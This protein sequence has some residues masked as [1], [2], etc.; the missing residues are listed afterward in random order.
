[1]R[2]QRL[3]SASTREPTTN[4]FR[5]AERHQVLQR[6]IGLAFGRPRGLV[7]KRRRSRR[8][9]SETPESASRRA[10]IVTRTK[11]A[12]FFMKNRKSP[13]TS[14]RYSLSAGRKIP[15][16]AAHTFHHLC[17]IVPIS[18]VFAPNLRLLP[19]ALFGSFATCVSGSPS[20][21]GLHHDWSGIPPD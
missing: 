21:A 5:K 11:D 17:A 19:L 10:Q 7:G 12:P 13:L 16:R 14:D 9:I 1:M 18:A 20:V 15:H 2:A 8:A 3:F 6:I 4:S